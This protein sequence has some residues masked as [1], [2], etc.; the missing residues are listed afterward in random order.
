M[1]TSITLS[2]SLLDV[3]PAGR[4]QPLSNDCSIY[5]SNLRMRVTRR[6][7]IVISRG[8]AYILCFPSLLCLGDPRTMAARFS[9]RFVVKAT[10]LCHHGHQLTRYSGFLEF[11]LSEHR[12]KA[13]TGRASGC[14]TPFYMHGLQR[15]QDALEN[16]RGPNA[17]A[18]GGGGPGD[19]CSE[20][21][22]AV[23]AA[24]LSP[25]E[26]ERASE[27][28]KKRPRGADGQL[29]LLPTQVVKEGT[30]TAGP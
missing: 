2:C 15:S 23:S 21:V 16:D 10:S 27:R 5:A 22:S 13:W 28:D 30:E 4:S 25:Q 19:R 9:R 6:R 3:C 29:R 18:F 17:V 14:G 11:T 7:Y 12:I 24:F 1:K 8:A 20:D 26:R